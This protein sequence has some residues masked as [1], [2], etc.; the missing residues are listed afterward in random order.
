M[1]Y[2]MFFLGLVTTPIAALI[3]LASLGIDRLEQLISALNY[4]NEKLKK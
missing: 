3:Y 2:L 4:A 1:A